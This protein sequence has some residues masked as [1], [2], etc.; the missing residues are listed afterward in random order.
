METLHG[1][2][3]TLAHRIVDYR[4]QNGA[5]ESLDELDDVKG[6]GEK[7]LENIRHCITL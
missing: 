2:G 6:I 4:S 5:F 7:T 3:E 1:I